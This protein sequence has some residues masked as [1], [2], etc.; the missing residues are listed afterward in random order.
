MVPGQT[1]FDLLA[2]FDRPKSAELPDFE[3]VEEVIPDD[4]SKTLIHYFA[5]SALPNEESLDLP[6]KTTRG[7]RWVLQWTAALAVLVLAASVL[8]Q[9]A[10]LLAAE[11]KMRLAAQAGAREATLPHPT[12]ESVVSAIERRLTAYPQLIKQL[13]ISVMQNGA[14][15]QRRFSQSEGDR[16]AVMLWAP[17]SSI[18]PDWLRIFT[19]WH[20]GARIHADAERQVPGRRFAFEET[21]GRAGG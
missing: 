1:S 18:M 12:Y 4:S 20:N 10:F 21:P 17:N 2:H 5:P 11:Q 3:W 19:N 6:R 9:F 8:T 13:H 14:T 16:F 7:V 15:V